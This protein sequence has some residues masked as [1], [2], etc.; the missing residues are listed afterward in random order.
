MKISIL[1]RQLSLYGIKILKELQTS[2]DAR[3]SRIYRYIGFSFLH[4]FSIPQSL[5]F[6][7]FRHL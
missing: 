7:L 2:R 5:E 4:K 1:K 6:T 3:A